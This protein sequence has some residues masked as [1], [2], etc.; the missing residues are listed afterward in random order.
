GTLVDTPFL[1][2]RS[3]TRAEGER[4]L[5]GLAFPP[6][7]AQS[8]R[9]YV[10][11]TD[12]NG[13]TVI[14]Q[15]RVSAN[16]D[17]ATASSEIILLPINQPFPNHNGGQLR[18]GPDGYLYIGMGDGGSAG[19]PRGNGQNA[20]VLL[21]KLLRVD[22]ESDPGRVRI[23]PDNPFA[24]RPGMRGEIWALGLRNP[25]RFT[26]DRATKDLWIA[27]VGQDKYEEIDFQPASSRGGENYG[28][29]PME[30]LHCYVAGCNPAGLT[31][32]VFEYPHT[33]ECSVTGGFVYRG[34]GS[35]GLRGLYLYGDLCSGKIWGLERQGGNWVNRL[36]LSS[37]FSITTFG[38]DEAGEMYVAN[39]N[40][41]TVYRISGSAAPRVTIAGAVNAASFL[42]GLVAGS[43]ATQFAAGVRD[44]AGIDSAVTVPFATV[45]AGVSITLN[46]SAVPIR[47]VAN[48]NGQ[49][50]VNFQ[51]PFGLTGS[52]VSLVVSRDGRSSAAI[53]VP[54][55]DVQPGIYTTDGTQA[56]VVHN[57]DF[58]LATAARP[59]D[60]NEYAFIYAAGLGRVI[61]PPTAGNVALA[62]PLSSAL[63]DVRVTIAGQ[64]AEVQF[65]GLAPGFVGVYQVNFRVPA[66]VPSGSQTLVLSA[67]AVSG[68]ET[69]V[70]I[71]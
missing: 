62:L 45:L 30:G 39:A 26:F 35:P 2:I 42:P 1:D 46:G 48:V 28:W 64:A 10:N 12:L 23:P 70:A 41:S 6:G 50:Q 71:R 52:T 44:D 55:L 25:W 17:V 67:G 51:V 60:R 4:G 66:D 40:N 53:D 57:T 38:E 7:F 27:D 69:R 43:L 56:I 49:E 15:Y 22:V 16:A 47:A 68:P 20:G 9:F 59:L 54:L 5:L 34:R 19:D 24:N 11:Y 3:K 33:P 65:A 32:P 58:T 21:G 36:L 13:N 37:G 14:A 18:F 29:N 61:N 8:Q 63:A 31:L